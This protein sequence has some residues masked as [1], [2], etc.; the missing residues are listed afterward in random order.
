VIQA[1]T[2]QATII[3]VDDD[4]RGRIT[5]EADIPYICEVP[6]K[7]PTKFIL[8]AGQANAPEV[9]STIEAALE[10]TARQARFVRN[11]TFASELIDGT[12]APWQVNW[13]MTAATAI[14]R[15]NASTGNHTNTPPGGAA[16]LS[17]ATVSPAR[18]AVTVDATLRHRVDEMSKNDRGACFMA[19]AL[20]AA[21]EGDLYETPA[22]LI[23]A[24]S[25][26]AA[27]LNGRFLHR[28]N[29][30]VDPADTPVVPS[31]PL[32]TAAVA[33]GAVVTNVEDEAAPPSEAA[34]EP[35]AGNVQLPPGATEAG[36]RDWVTLNG[37]TRE[38]VQGVIRGAGHDTMAA[39]LSVPGHTVPGLASLIREKLGRKQ[40]LL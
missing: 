23:E 34:S 18:A 36:L 1:T 29:G 20:G 21:N 37:W 27:W 13:R 33:A 16:P 32:V 12:E 30:S 38:W 11:G 17:G 40:V 25:E 28:L 4:G 15:S 14:S 22:A 19:I 7:F 35:S 6:V 5:L 39:Y 31:S 8:W 26:I 2:E 24:A 9:G 10:P 3:R